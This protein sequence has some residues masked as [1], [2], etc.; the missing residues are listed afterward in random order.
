M[1]SWQM[2]IYREEKEWGVNR[3]INYLMIL[4]SIIV[5]ANLLGKFRLNEIMIGIP[6]RGPIDEANRSSA[7]RWRYFRTT[8]DRPRRENVRNGCCRHARPEKWLVS[9]DSWMTWLG[10]T[11]STP[12][13]TQWRDQCIRHWEMLVAKGVRPEYGGAGKRTMTWPVYP[14]IVVF[15]FIHKFRA[16]FHT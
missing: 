8:I 16:F 1:V 3:R 6:S 11:L 7:N 13:N 12:G 10:T 14:V 9:L 15:F 5:F 4:S 2:P